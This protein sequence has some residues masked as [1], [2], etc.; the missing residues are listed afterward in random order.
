MIDSAVHRPQDDRERL[1]DEDEDNGDLGQVLA[2]LQLFAPAAQRGKKETKLAE[3]TT[4]LSAGNTFDVQHLRH[5]T[6]SSAQYFGCLG[7][8]SSALH[9]KRWQHHRASSWLTKAGCKQLA[10][11]RLCLHAHM[12]I[13]TQLPE[14][15]K[16]FPFKRKLC[17][18]IQ[19]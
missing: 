1:V 16:P 5:S 2:V 4:A 15:R 13:G 18:A 11:L 19:R 6:G 7:V 14:H 3:R 12:S 8:I 9:R 10:G 17:F